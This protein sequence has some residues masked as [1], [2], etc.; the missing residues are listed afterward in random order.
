MAQFNFSAEEQLNMNKDELAQ[1]Q[2][3]LLSYS[4]KTENP[5]NKNRWQAAAKK[6]GETSK[7]LE[8]VI[9]EAERAGI[10][11]EEGEKSILT[12]AE[13]GKRMRAHKNENGNSYEM[14]ESALGVD[15]ITLSN[16]LGDKAK[17]LMNDPNASQ[18]ISTGILGFAA[19]EFAFSA[20]GF[21][22]ALGA[23]Q[24]L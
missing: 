13:V 4:K 18:K 2:S 10:K 15:D 9:A 22:G 20:L 5:S 6:I 17:D 1:A 16:T 24:S 19:A 3:I 23:G 14:D 8:T 7:T 12:I 11:F 21:G